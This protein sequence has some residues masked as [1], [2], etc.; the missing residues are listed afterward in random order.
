MKILWVCNIMLPLV[1]EYLGQEASNKEGWLAGLADTILTKE[2]DNHIELAVAFPVKK[3]MS[4]NRLQV[5]IKGTQS[6]LICYSFAEDTDH[7]EIYDAS[8]EV[9]I[10]EIVEDWKPDI[11]HCFGTEFPH[12]LAVTKVC[13]KEKVLVGIQ[14][15]CKYCTDVYFADLPERVIKRVT[16]RDFVR[17]DSVFQQKTKYISRSKN[18]KEIL[19]NTGHVTGRTQMDL[20]YAT[21][22]NPQVQ[23]HFMHETLRANFY[24]GQ[25]NLPDCEKYSIFISQGDY[26][27]KGLHY[28]LRAMPLILEK[29]P[30]AK[31]YVA[32]NPIVREKNMKGRLK[33]SSYGKY[34]MEL[35]EQEKIE[36]KVIFLGKMSA[37]E[38]KQQFLKS[39][40][41]LCASAVENSPNSLGE[42]ML[43]GMP[44]VT[45][46]VGGIPSMF[47]EGI[48]GLTYPGFGAKE[49]SM[50]TDKEIAQAKYLAQIVCE[51]WQDEKQMC[52]YAREASIQARK[53]HDAKINYQ[54]LIEIYKKI[55]GK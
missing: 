41:F 21:E 50:E 37:Q 14:G 26:P 28:V 4:E 23:Y 42:A 1:A 31:L 16:F 55:M 8:L 2:Q 45:A 44:C 38:M 30:Q 32:G 15:V 35:L 3:K 10:S 24:E 34:I 52:N 13:P 17:R 33:I 19:Q 25:W 53:N 36:D 27:L 40:L 20:E 39:N 22:C 47:R 11:I 43:L 51:M 46:W 18:E 54:R 48:D 49:Y 7:P 5:P 9:Q 12:T 29:Y 6:N